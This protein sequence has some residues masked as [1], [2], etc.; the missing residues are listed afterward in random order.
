LIAWLLGIM[1]YFRAVARQFY[2]LLFPLARRNVR[3]LAWFKRWFQRLG[4]RVKMLLKSII[5]PSKTPPPDP[6]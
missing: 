1:I 6:D 3:L 2:K 5:P 4:A